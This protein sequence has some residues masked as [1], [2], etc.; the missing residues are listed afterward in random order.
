[1]KSSSFIININFFFS[2]KHLIIIISLFSQMI[3]INSNLNASFLTFITS[4][5]LLKLIIDCIFYYILIL[6]YLFHSYLF[7]PLDIYIF[8]LEFLIMLIIKLL[9]PN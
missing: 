1:M 4:F 2:L 9:I 6:I 7:D 3:L 8:Y 5:L